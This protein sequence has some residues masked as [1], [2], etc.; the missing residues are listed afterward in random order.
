M[1]QLTRPYLPSTPAGCPKLSREARIW[2]CGKA[3][4]GSKTPCFSYEMGLMHRLTS[5]ER[6]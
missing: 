3:E 1:G 5:Q 6:K 2:W 4:I